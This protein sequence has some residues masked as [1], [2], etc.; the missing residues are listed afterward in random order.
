MAAAAVDRSLSW[1]KHNGNAQASA[2]CAVGGG[3]FTGL[4]LRSVTN[5]HDRGGRTLKRLELCAGRGEQ[6]MESR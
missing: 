3:F 6:E 4:D 2:V 5:P 1:R